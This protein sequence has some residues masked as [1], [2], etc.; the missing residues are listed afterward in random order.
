[1][2]LKIAFYPV[3]PNIDVLN[4]L[5]LR[6]C[7]HFGSD[8][9]KKV[10]F[11]LSSTILDKG[12]HFSPCLGDEFAKDA[13]IY[14]EQF[15]YEFVDDEDIKEIISEVDV[16]LKWV[17]GESNIDSFLKGL[18]KK[19]YRVD[20]NKVRQEGSFYI[21]CCF[22]SSS[23]KHVQTLESSE[24][25]IAMK[26]VLGSFENGWVIATGPSV[27]KYRDYEFSS[28]F[29]VVCNSVIL[30]RELMDYVKPHVLVFADPIFHFG[31]SAYA[32]SFRDAVARELESSKISIVTPLKYYD[33]LIKRYP[34]FKDRIIGVPFE[35]SKVFN[36]DLTTDFAVKTTANILT[37]LLLPIASTFSKEINIIGCDGR[38][39]DQDSYFWSH[40]AKVQINDKMANI[41]RVH[42]GFFDI[43]YNEYYFEHCHL[44]ECLMVQGEAEGRSF[45]NAGFSHIPALY[46]R[47]TSL[48]D[49]DER[50]N[51]FG[52]N[53]ITILIEPD[54]V[55]SS[56]HYVEWH[57]SLINCLNDKNIL[58]FVNKKQDVSL[59]HAE[60]VP[61]FTSHSWAVSRADYCFEENYKEHNSYINFFNELFSA[62][63]NVSRTREVTDFKLFFYYGSC[64]ILSGLVDVEKKLAEFGVSLKCSVCIFHESVF[65]KP[66]LT[67]PRFAFD[68][69]ITLLHS[70]VYREKFKVL[71][72]T[73]NLANEIYV[74][75][76]VY[77]DVMPNPIPSS[78]EL[79]FESLKKSGKRVVH[80]PCSLTAEKGEA[81]TKSFLASIKNV[82]HDWV[83]TCRKS[84][85]LADYESDNVVLVDCS[86]NESYWK[87]MFQCDLIVI[88]YM[89]PN[90]KYRTSGIIVDAMYAGKPVIV[91]E[92]TWLSTVV[93]ENTFGLPVKYYSPVTLE[94]AINVIFRAYVFFET[95]S[96]SAYS[97]Y[98]KNNSWQKLICLA[99][100]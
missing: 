52:T 44:L 32:G 18:K 83:V 15:N 82:Q 92:D 55:G 28:S 89:S 65:N 23:T 8:T 73:E 100:L 91:L 69:K 14:A 94:T 41:K 4:D 12:K 56:G 81:I 47:A 2:T 71:A 10:Y 88:P 60:A 21:Q 22:D 39:I 85:V 74:R 33:M 93:M 95:S 98:S 75:L 7:W 51:N 19:V 48:N 9:N 67:K 5:F 16:V 90:F 49:N 20:K 63:L 57:N 68:S 3:I 84:E 53:E 99:D 77:L 42:P 76:G 35:T 31:I 62:I 45:I 34:A 79:T 30:D 61:V 36:F 58:L 27:E 70:M 13:L 96:M 17:E 38:P 54:G 66:N 87:A 6:A 80:F 97:K 26:K 78:P 29:N 40:G 72:V 46:S 43:D 37:L 24:K 25:L 50:E 11:A 86:S 1:M 64:Q 59:Y